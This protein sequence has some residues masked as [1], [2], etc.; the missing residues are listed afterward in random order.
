MVHV[1]EALTTPT[2]EKEPLRNNAPFEDTLLDGSGALE[3]DVDGSDC[4]FWNSVVLEL[5]DRGS[6]GGAGGSGVFP[7]P[8]HENGSYDLEYED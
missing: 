1:L 8:D 4:G 3:H 7:E 6:D 2:P 5:S